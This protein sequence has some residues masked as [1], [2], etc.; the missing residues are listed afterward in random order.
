MSRVLQTIVFDPSEFANYPKEALEG[1]FLTSLFEIF[2]EN[3]NKNLAKIKY[4]V[5]RQDIAGFKDQ[6][7][8]LKGI[9]GNVKAKQLEAITRKC[10][11]IDRMCFESKENTDYILETL[12][13]CLN[14]T[15]QVLFA[16]LKEEFR[17][18]S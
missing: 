11:E 13:T 18:N 17:K 1:E 5:E 8:A 7:H 14:E 15:R 6:M 4:T 12:Q 2:L 9:A 10:Q 16:Y 3:A